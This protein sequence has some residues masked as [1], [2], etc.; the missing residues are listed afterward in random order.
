MASSS[1]SSRSG[2]CSQ[3]LVL[4]RL[5]RFGAQHGHRGGLEQVGVPVVHGGER[6]H[7]G[8]RLGVGDLVGRGQ[9]VDQHLCDLLVG[10]HDQLGDRVDAAGDHRDE[11]SLRPGGQPG[12]HLVGGSRPARHPYQ[13]GHAQTA[14]QHVDHTDHARRAPPPQ[15]GEPALDGRLTGSDD[16]G[17]HLPRG[18]AVELQGGQQP[19]VELVEQEV[20]RHAHAVCSGFTAKSRPEPSKSRIVTSEPAISPT[21]RLPGSTLG[22]TGRLRCP[23]SPIT[24]VEWR[25][26]GIP[27]L[28]STVVREVRPLP[29]PEGRHVRAARRQFADVGVVTA[30]PAEASSRP[31]SRAGDATQR[32]G[33]GSYP[34]RDARPQPGVVGVPDPGEPAA[35][36]RAHRSCP[37][38]RGR[39]SRPCSA[40]RP[41]CADGSPPATRSS[42]TRSWRASAPRMLSRHSCSK[43]SPTPEITQTVVETMVASQAWR[44]WAQRAAS[45]HVNE[46]DRTSGRLTD[47]LL[48]G[49]SL[50]DQYRIEQDQSTDYI[51]AER[52]QAIADQRRALIAALVTTLVLLVSAGDPRAAAWSTAAVHRRATAP[53]AAR[54]Y[55]RARLRRPLC[56]CGTDRCRR[57]GCGGHRP[58]R[59]GHR[60][61]ARR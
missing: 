25:R 26:R 22:R 12:R 7:H 28:A 5:H 55:R 34:V 49:K 6:P 19:P 10:R 61:A 35:G 17:D 31:R 40:R 43:G 13:H 60:P 56:P 18:T 21:D 58:G 50:F 2:G 3:H 39:R 33:H 36:G 23:F 41:V 57:A 45:M 59:A 27:R 51:T 54:D 15:G 11:A 44:E 30:G 42:S 9:L 20:G 14:A 1:G 8:Q 4:E 48:E 32:S 29:A 16:P 37:R 47:F 24:A 38:T 46:D 52:D 53:S